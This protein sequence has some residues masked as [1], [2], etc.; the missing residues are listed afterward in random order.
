MKKNELIAKL[1]NRKLTA[2]ASELCFVATANRKL[3]YAATANRNLCF[4]AADQRAAQAA[5]A[6]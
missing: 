2:G 1:V 6:K 3:C 5:S 4:A